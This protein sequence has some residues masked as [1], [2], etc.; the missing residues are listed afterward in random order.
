MN[1]IRRTVLVAAAVV[2]IVAT[3]VALAASPTRNSTMTDSG[4]ARPGAPATASAPVVVARIQ[5]PSTLFQLSGGLGAVWFVDRSIDNYSTLRRIDP[6]TNKI[7]ASYLL[8][9]SAGGIAVGEGGIWVTMYYDNTVERIDQHG[10]VVARIP[11]GLQPATIHVAFGS[12]WVSNHHGRS[13]SRIDPRTNRVVA[14]LPAGDQ[15][16]FR[17]G[18]QL[19][20]DDGRYLYLYSSNGDRPF[21]RVD[22]RTNAVTT[23]PL[24]NDLCGQI[25]VVHGSFFVGYCTQTGLMQVDA[26]TGRLLRVIPLPHD[27]TQTTANGLAVVAYQGDTWVGYGTAY[28]PDTGASSGGVLVDIDPTTSTIKQQIDVGG[29]VVTLNVAAGD[30]WITDD[31]DGEIVRL[32]TPA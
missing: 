25:A 12:V 17:D 15:Q 5:V 20:T 1:A 13:I 21:E 11:V 16:M 18:P 3:P 31:T 14:T 4:G 19:L 23:Y 32:H 24:T 22:P 29:A 9:S 26:A 8:D 28:D 27:A 7:T 10:R 2:G 6:A 30:L